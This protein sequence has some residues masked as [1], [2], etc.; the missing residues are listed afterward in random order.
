MEKAYIS[1]DLLINLEYLSAEDWIEDFHLQSSPIG[2]GK[3]KK[4][5]FMPGFTEKTGEFIAD[6]NFL[7]RCKD[8]CEK[9]N[10]S[11]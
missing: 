7:D 4:I 8:V 11:R 1:S 10:L 2:K 5:F 9:K 6:S 3:L